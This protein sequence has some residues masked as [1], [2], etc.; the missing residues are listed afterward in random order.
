MLQDAR[1]LQAARPSDQ[2]MFVT[3][4]CRVLA[5]EV[6]IKEKVRALAAERPRLPAYGVAVAMYKGMALVHWDMNVCFAHMQTNLLA[7]M[8]ARLLGNNANSNTFINCLE[9]AE[10]LVGAPNPKNVDL[11]P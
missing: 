3:A 7:Y 1:Q 6:P 10:L 9:L 8:E 11:E 4:I 2:D 5:S